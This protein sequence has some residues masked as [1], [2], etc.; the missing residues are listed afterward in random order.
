MWRFRFFCFYFV[1]ENLNLRR[2]IGTA[3]V[4]GRLLS[5]ASAKDVGPAVASALISLSGLG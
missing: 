3:S 4:R 5:L 1:R 2:A